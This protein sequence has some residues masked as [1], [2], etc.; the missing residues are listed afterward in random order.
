MKRIP[1][2]DLSEC[3]E[4]ESCLDVCPEVFIRNPETG[5]IEVVDLAEYPEEAVQE[6]I[7]MCPTDCIKWEEIPEPKKQKETHK[8]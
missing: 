2:V 3:N 5:Q 8:T 1:V 4:C 7:A 6:A